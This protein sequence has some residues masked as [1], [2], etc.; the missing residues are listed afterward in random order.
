[1]SQALKT[2]YIDVFI[3]FILFMIFRQ[4]LIYYP[5]SFSGHKC[6][7]CGEHKIQFQNFISKKV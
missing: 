1:M 2:I 3:T 5:I 7:L 4:F 6:M